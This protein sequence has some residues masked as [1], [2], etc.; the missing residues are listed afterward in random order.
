MDYQ[1]LTLTTVLILFGLV[2]VYSA[3]G[4]WADQR[5]HDSLYFLKRQALWALLGLPAMILLAKTDY[6][7][8]RRLVWP[9]LALSVLALAAALFTRPVGGARR[10][11]RFGWLG[12]QPA[13][14]AKAAMILFLADYFDRKRSKV[15]SPA[16]GIVVPWAV[17]GL[18]LGLIALEPDLGTPALMF[19]VATAVMYIGGA[20][21][22]YALAAVAC[23]I[24]VLVYE[25][26]RYPYRRHRLANFLSPWSDPH[27]KGYQLV[28]SMLAVGSG[29]WFGRGLGSSQLKL[30]YLPTP[31][32]DFI[33]PIIAEELG[34]VGSLAV[35]LLFAA[36]FLR[37][38]RIAWS[39]PNLF[40]ELM[41]AG[42]SI[43]ICAQAY[44]NIAMSIGL[45][46]TKGVPLPFFSAGGSS[47]L[48]TLSEIGVLLSISRQA[49]V[50]A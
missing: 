27:G 19:L 13:E 33:F 34:L 39:A 17:L 26:L 4:I 18:L 8:L 32:T 22:R 49:K 10:W 30:M 9:L 40:G 28:Q 50:A 48:I 43:L 31:H 24:P 7:R 21:L 3:S 36:V 29:G 16:R 5:Y 1:L 42:I 46:P 6:N 25:L 11:I 47:L 45:L 12:F 38:M 15:A 37:G 41:A 2:M 44:F 23:A 14:A 35:L 20:R